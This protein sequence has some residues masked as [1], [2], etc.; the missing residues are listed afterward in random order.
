MGITANSGPFVQ[1]GITQTSSGAVTEYNEERGPATFD[2]G[3][4]VLDP[5]PNFNYGPGNAVGTQLKSF[6]NGWVSADW[7]PYA[8]NSSAISMSSATPI[9]TGTS[10][11]TITA[12]AS[13]GVTLT[14]IIAP[15]NGT[16]VTCW[17]I[18]STAAVL[19]FG[20]SGTIAAWNPASGTGRVINLTTTT[21]NATPIICLVNGRDMYG[22]KMTEAITASTL[23]S[24]GIGRKAFKYI[25]SVICATTT[26]NSTGLGIGF[27]DTFGLPLKLPYMTNDMSIAFSTNYFSP[28]AAVAVTSAIVS[29]ASTT[30]QTSTTSDVRGVYA[31]T[32]ATNGTAANIISGS[33]AVRVQIKQNITANMVSAITASDQTAFFGLTQ[34]S[35]I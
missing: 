16:T 17:A 2:L 23:S 14:T 8:I 3:F 7:I 4:G 5:R 21:T 13:N 24:V 10:A 19:P 11:V 35:A 33:A 34:Y 27:I 22:F 32:I 29:A 12:Y 6:Y 31:S 26:I 25:T 30:T 28:I 20:Q 18:D 9:A 15:E 1:Y